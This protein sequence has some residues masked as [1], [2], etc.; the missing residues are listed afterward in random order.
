MIGIA[1]DDLGLNVVA[2]FAAGMDIP[3]P[4]LLADE[5]IKNGSSPLGNLSVT[6]LLMLFEK[7]GRLTRV[8]AGFVDPRLI[9]KMILELL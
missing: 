6:P 8:I 2:P 1:L 5:R 7:S 3:Y 4:V 9:E